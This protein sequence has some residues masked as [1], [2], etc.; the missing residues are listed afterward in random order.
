MDP[1]LPASH[2]DEGYSE[3]PLTSALHQNWSVAVSALRSPADIPTW[4]ARNASSLPSSI[5]AGP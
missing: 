2:T 5:K 3:D 1:F 4:I